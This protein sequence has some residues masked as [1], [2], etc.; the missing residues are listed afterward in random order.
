MLFVVV[1]V[2]VLVDFQSIEFF[3]GIFHCL[4]LNQFASLLKL[5][6]IY[7]VAKVMLI[8]ELTFNNNIDKFG[9]KQVSSNE[10]KERL[11]I[12]KGF[13]LGPVM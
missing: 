8:L 3:W 5:C 2:V 13:W 11:K 4:K 10:D 9:N 1:V 12:G 7:C 6:Y